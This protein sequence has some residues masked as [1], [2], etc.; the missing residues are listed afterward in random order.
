MTQN[1]SRITRITLLVV[2]AGLSLQTLAQTQTYPARPI[3]IIVPGTAGS[4][5]D[6]TARAIAQRFTDAW[7][8]Q[9][10]IDNR[11]GAGGIIAHDIVAK[12]KPSLPP[13]ARLPLPR[14]PEVKQKVGRNDPCHCGSRKKF[15]T[16]CMRK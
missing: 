1:A 15:K 6:F 2:L 12:A 8:Q 16:C 14:K 13:T 9:G 3:R 11:A 5:N 10:V 4:S 7:G